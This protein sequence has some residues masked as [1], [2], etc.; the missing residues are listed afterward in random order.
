M[1]RVACLLGSPRAGGNSDALTDALLSALAGQ[2]AQVV[3]HAL[4]DL[5]F[6]GYRPLPDGTLTT[7]SAH[8]QD[9]LTPV[10]ADVTQADLVVLATP[11]YFCNMTA[12]LKQALDRFFCFFKPDYVTNPEPS[13]LGRDKVLVLVQ[14]QGE[15]PE[16]YADLL[17]QYAPALDKLG[18]ARRE[19]LRACG[20]RAP[21]DVA[22]QHEVMNRAEALALDLMKGR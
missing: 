5:E 20:V 2:G 12:L 21:G 14:V 8:Q 18:F 10:L 6:D 4:R 15:G 11:I 1:T 13:V 7:D 3:C 9:D 22:G 19:L 16:R 17:D